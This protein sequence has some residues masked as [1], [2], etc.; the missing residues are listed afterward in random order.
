MVVGFAAVIGLASCAQTGVSAADA[1]RVGCP[2]VDSAVAGGSVA[3]QA[4][5]TGLKALRDS[6][7]LDPQPTQW[8][9]AAIGALEDPQDVPPEAKALIVDGCAA[10]GY[11]LRDLS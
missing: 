11:P 5:V 7:T 8:L 4:A 6:G 10:Q 1:Y 2:A 9:D 3:G